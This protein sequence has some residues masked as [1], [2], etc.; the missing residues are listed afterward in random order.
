MLVFF[1]TYVS[2]LCVFENIVEYIQVGSCLKGLFHI[3]TIVLSKFEFDRWFKNYNFLLFC[4]C[5]HVNSIFFWPTMINT[6]FVPDAEC[7]FA[8]RNISHYLF[9]FISVRGY[10]AQ[11]WFVPLPPWR[12]DRIRTRCGI[13]IFCFWGTQNCAKQIKSSQ[14]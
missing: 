2:D 12:M 9:I 8:G 3:N 7:T 10:R 11:P 14:I 1:L 6:A 5:L 4:N 13:Y